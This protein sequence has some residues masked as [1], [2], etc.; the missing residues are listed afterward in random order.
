MNLRKNNYCI[1]FL[2]F[3]IKI[4]K[5]KRKKERKK[6]ILKLFIINLQK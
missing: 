5:K 6:K 3:S 2:S 1:V 4:K